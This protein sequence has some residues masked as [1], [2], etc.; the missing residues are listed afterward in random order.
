MTQRTGANFGSFN[1]SGETDCAKQNWYGSY[2]LYFGDPPF[3]IDSLSDKLLA[4][5]YPFTSVA[6]YAYPTPAP[7]VSSRTDQTLTTRQE[8]L[9]LQRAL[10]NPPGQF[11]QNVLQYLGTFSRERNRPAPDWP[12]L[13]N[14]LSEGRFNLNNLALVVPNP[15]ECVIAHGLKGRVRS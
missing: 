11:S 13:Q 9:R 12:N 14:N 15:S 1:Y 2:L 6:N 3:L 8:L 4:S 7:G 10:N 5:S